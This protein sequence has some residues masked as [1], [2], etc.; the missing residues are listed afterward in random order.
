MSEG[1]QGQEDGELCWCGNSDPSTFL[2]LMTIFLSMI[3]LG[4]AIC[5][6]IILDEEQDASAWRCS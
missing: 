2:T 4:S 6:H 3:P 1:L 5:S